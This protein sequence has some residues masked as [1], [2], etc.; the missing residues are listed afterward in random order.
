[1][2]NDMCILALYC[3]SPFMSISLT[4]C[5]CV[6]VSLSM[7]LDIVIH[8]LTHSTGWVLV[9]RVVHVCVP[10]PSH[11]LCGGRHIHT[12]NGTHVH[13]LRVSASVVLMVNIMLVSHSLCVWTLLLLPYCSK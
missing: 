4:V 2:Y 1:M 11:L 10:L 3:F 7:I 6:C 5:V 9:I 13:V 8:A 12:V